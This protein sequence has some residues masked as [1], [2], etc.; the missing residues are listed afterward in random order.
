MSRTFRKKRKSDKI[1]RD[2]EGQ[3]AA[4]SCRHHGSCD[5][6]KNDRTFEKAASLKDELKLH[7]LENDLSRTRDNQIYLRERQI[8]SYTWNVPIS[9]IDLI[10]CEPIG[11]L[12][13][14]VDNV[15]RGYLDENL[16]LT[17]GHSWFVISN[18]KYIRID[19]P[20]I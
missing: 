15:W 10:Y 18:G 4:S 9:K 17:D 8:L 6:C 13:V 5:Y 14:Y 11:E 1:I 19:E 20:L 16:P 12:C 2:G 7:E 3:Y